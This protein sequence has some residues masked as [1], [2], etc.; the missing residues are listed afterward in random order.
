MQVAGGIL[1]EF[2]SQFLFCLKL[3][4]FSVVV[5]TDLKLE[6][7]MDIRRNYGQKTSGK[8]FQGVI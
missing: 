5:E 7:L 4:T 2:Y 3:I 6:E 8:Y 1:S